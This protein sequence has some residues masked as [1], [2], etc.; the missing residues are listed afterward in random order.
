M[1]YGLPSVPE[2][3]SQS[4]NRHIKSSSICALPTESPNST[5]KRSATWAEAQ[6]P[7]H[8][9][10]GRSPGADRS[11]PSSPTARRN[12]GVLTSPG[13]SDN[14]PSREVNEFAADARRE[15]K[16]L[17]LEISNSSLL[18]YNRSLEREIKKQ[19][20]ELKRYRRL[21]RAGRFSAAV[22]GDFEG[23]DDESALPHLDGSLSGRPSSPFEE[24]VSDL[25]EFDSDEDAT[26]SSVA[27]DRTSKEARQRAKDEAQL[28]ADLR[29]HREL[30]LDT[31]RV[32]RSLQRCLAWTEDLI[33]DGQRALER[34]EE[35]T[36]GGRVLDEDEDDETAEEEDEEEDEDEEGDLAAEMRDMEAFLSIGTQR[37]SGVEM[38]TR[39]ALLAAAANKAQ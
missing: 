14:S 5:R 12:P 9:L 3:N 37:D 26:S 8:A 33:K 19:K 13:V 28:K 2:Q 27:L 10:A 20:G 39:D 6:S 30:L 32:N 16:V 22:N 35:V 4:P 29:K 1:S 7:V 25:D 31:A 11:E 24:D 23:S 17:D 34:K 21:S 38:E 18:A 15:R 36:L